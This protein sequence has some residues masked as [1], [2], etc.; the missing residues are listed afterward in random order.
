MY[1][2]SVTFIIILLKLVLSSKIVDIDVLP[3]TMRTTNPAEK[4]KLFL[5]DF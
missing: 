2:Y 4:N 1:L 5:F 3:E